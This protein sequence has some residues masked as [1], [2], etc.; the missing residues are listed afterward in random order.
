MS[1]ACRHRRSSDQSGL[2]K[3]HED[4]DLEGTSHAHQCSVGGWDRIQEHRKDDEFRIR[5]R[6][7]VVESLLSAVDEE[8]P[9]GDRAMDGDE[10]DQ[11]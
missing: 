1:D 8:G 5:L 4:L 9:E 10:R 2:A 7:Q 11:A 6:I 3:G